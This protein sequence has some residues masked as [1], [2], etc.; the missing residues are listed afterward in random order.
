[1]C[2][3]ITYSAAQRRVHAFIYSFNSATSERRSQTDTHTHFTK[4]PCRCPAVGP[5]CVYRRERLAE[6]GGEE[7]DVARTSERHLAGT[8]GEYK[9]KSSARFGVCSERVH[10]RR[11][12]DPTILRCTVSTYCVWLPVLYGTE[13]RDIFAQMYGHWQPRRT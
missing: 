10:F 4:P 11:L 8:N 9:S 5:R 7:V 13:I 6:R 1:M 12:S 2:P 3:Y